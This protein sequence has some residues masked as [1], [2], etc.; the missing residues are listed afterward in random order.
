MS[1]VPRFYLDS[2]AVPSGPSLLQLLALRRLQGAN[3]AT[4]AATAILR[5]R[6]SS[7]RSPEAA[8]AR[9]VGANSVRAAPRLAGRRVEAGVRD[10]HPNLPARVA[11]LRADGDSC[12]DDVDAFIRAAGEQR[13]LEPACAH[14]LSRMLICACR[15]LLGRLWDHF[16]GYNCVSLS[17]AVSIYCIQHTSS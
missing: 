3:P 6:P 9:G 8:I 11:R 2:M 14:L 13:H 4:A 5:L 7:S 12:L 17:S 15:A 16:F 10:A 1:I